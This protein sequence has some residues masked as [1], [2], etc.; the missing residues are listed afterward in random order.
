MTSMIDVVFLLLIFFIA[1]SALVR[2]E[3]NLESGIEAKKKAPARREREVEPTVVDVVLSKT[4]TD[5]NG[6]F[7]FVYK[8]GLHEFT[9][10]EEEKEEKLTKKVREKKQLDVGR[11]LRGA[12]GAFVRV[13]NEAP[14]EMA[15]AAVQACKS[16]GY[17]D[18]GYVPMSP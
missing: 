4:R 15:A 17:A 16:A 3:R 12:A 2:M 5:E 11:A 13:S 1:T 10:E 14:F 7:V 18:V 9:W 6:K 8:L